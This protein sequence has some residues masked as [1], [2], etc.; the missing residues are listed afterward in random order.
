MFLEPVWKTLLSRLVGDPY[1]PAYQDV[2]DSWDWVQ[3]L[4]F[5][6]VIRRH[7]KTHPKLSTVSSWN[8]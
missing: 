7:F 8:R 1:C 6:H 4:Q 5:V 3:L 2:L